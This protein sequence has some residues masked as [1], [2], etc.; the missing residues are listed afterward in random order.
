M[1]K[2]TYK[3]QSGAKIHGVMGEFAGPAEI[4]HGA[5]AMRD[6]GYSKWDVFSPFPVHGIEEAMG[7]KP[8]KLPLIVGFIGLSMAC[9][10]FLF[11]YYVRAVD[12][13][14]VHQG[15]PPESWQVLI[16]VTFEIGVLFVPHLLPV[17]RGILETIYCTPASH[18]VDTARVTE[19]L[20][21]AYTPAKTPFVVVRPPDDPP[22]TPTLRDVQ[23]TNRVHINARVVCGRVVIVAA[24]DNLI[25]GASGQAIQNAN[26]ML[27]F[28]ETTGLD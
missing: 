27:G 15:K 13:P 12:Y 5:E 25:K 11:Q 7:L 20:R 9:V 6:H 10:G 3:T 2:K 24:I 22:S 16:P 19:V 17:E 21:H 26:L 8:T 4:S 1:S 23:H 28:P 18:H 14:I